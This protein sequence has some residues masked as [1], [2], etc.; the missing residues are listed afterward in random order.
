MGWC[1]GSRGQDWEIKK[2]SPP[3]C[4]NY[5][6]KVQV[7][8][9][10]K[11]KTT[12]TH[13]ISTIDIILFYL[14]LFK[15]KILGITTLEILVLTFSMILLMPQ[16]MLCRID[17]SL[18]LAWNFLIYG[19]FNLWYRFLDSHTTILSIN[20]KKCRFHSAKIMID[21]LEKHWTVAWRFVG[22][23]LLRANIFFNFSHFY[24]Y[25]SYLTD[26]HNFFSK[27]YFQIS[28]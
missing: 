10:K 2:S 15:N 5:S 9:P 1:K 14:D 18:M 12:D 13:N 27:N 20:C 26:S 19:V 28:K 3:L 24:P 7:I 21:K 6:S 17:F 11:T 8:L 25:K 4:M 23:I 16:D 22:S